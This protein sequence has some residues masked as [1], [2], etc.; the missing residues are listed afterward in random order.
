ML[1]HGSL[2]MSHCLPG[3]GDVQED[4]VGHTRHSK[5]ILAHVLVPDGDQMIHTVLLELFGH[6]LCSL[7]VE[8]HCVQVTGG[9]NGAKEGVGEG[10]ATRTWRQQG[11]RDQ[12]NRAEN[13]MMA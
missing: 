8:L 9:G 12:N 10:A 1:F 13:L 5:S 3:T 11:G 6:L 7:L 4:G 2:G